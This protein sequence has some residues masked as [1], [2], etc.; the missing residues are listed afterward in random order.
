MYVLLK[1][2][3]I[4]TYIYIYMRT[5]T[6]RAFGR[7]EIGKWS[8]EVWSQTPVSA[9]T[10]AEPSFADLSRAFSVYAKRRYVCIYIYIYTHIVMICHIM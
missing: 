9:P 6:P 4:H 5:P 8:L 7:L 2:L 3:I 10:L 1:L